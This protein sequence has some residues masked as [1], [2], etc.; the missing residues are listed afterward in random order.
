MISIVIKK[1]RKSQMFTLMSKDVDENEHS[2]E[3][4]LPLIHRRFK[5]NK[6]FPKL[7]PILVGALSEELETEYGKILS[8]YLADK[9]NVFIISSDFAHWYVNSYNLSLVRHILANRYFSF[10]C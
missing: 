5:H 3:M 6:Y 1:L 7:V 4:H 10:S 2:L 8:E 9:Q